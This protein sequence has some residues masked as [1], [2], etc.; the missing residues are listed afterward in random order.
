VKL[1]LLAID[2]SER[3]R[4]YMEY[5]AIQH[6]VPWFVTGAKANLGQAIGGRDVTVVGILDAGLARGI[7][8]VLEEGE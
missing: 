3:N 1:V 6:K 5:L 7:R 4:R 2:G 8:A